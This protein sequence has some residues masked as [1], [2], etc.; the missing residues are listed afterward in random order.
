ME[1]FHILHVTFIGPSNTKG[2]RFKIS[3]DRFGESKI[4]SFDYTATG[5][6][7]MA[8]NYLKTKG[9]EFI[10]KGEAKN[11]YYLISTTFESIK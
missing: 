7:T 6:D 8:E 10:G 1:N 4:I 2:A 5:I 11:G 9:F 3:S